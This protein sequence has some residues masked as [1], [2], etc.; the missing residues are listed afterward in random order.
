MGEAT[1]REV[2][3]YGELVGMRDKKQIQH[4]GLG[5]KLL[6]EAEMLA[7]NNGFATMKVISGVGVRDYYRKNG[8]RL[9]K[10]YLYKNLK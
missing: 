9:K 7:K 1:I 2:H 6:K 3:V 4:T 10:T 5:K 8:Y